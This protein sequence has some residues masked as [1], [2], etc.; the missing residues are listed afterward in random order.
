[1]P[2]EGQAVDT[3]TTKLEND[4]ARSEHQTVKLN[5]TIGHNTSRIT[6]LEEGVVTIRSD[7]CANLSNN[8]I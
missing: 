8:Q 6:S 5:D 3:R 7:F 4:I 1:M 2:E